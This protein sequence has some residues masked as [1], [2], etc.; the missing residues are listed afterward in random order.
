MIIKKNE[1]GCNMIAENNE[2]L[3]DCDRA[4]VRSCLLECGYILF[5]G[6]KPTQ[7]AFE[8]FTSSFGDCADTRHVH[9]PESGEGLGFHAEDAYNPYRPDTIWFFCYFQGTDGGVP[10]GVVDGV[11]IFKQLPKPWQSFCRSNQFIFSRQWSADIW[12]ALENKPSQSVI[13]ATLDAIPNI[14]FAFLPNGFI[15]IDTMVPIV[16]KTPRQ[17]ESFANTML[18]AISD[19]EY[20]GMMLANGETVPAELLS[21]IQTLCLENE[22]EVGWQTGDISV[23][24]N[25][26]MMHRRSFY[27]QVDRD[28]RVRHC[29]NFYGTVLPRSDSVFTQWIKQ[30]IQGDI[31][32]PTSIGSPLNRIPLT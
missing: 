18:Q 4:L 19:P 31:A 21:I 26:R 1:L 3:C 32:L 11:E 15:Q 28:L 10:T 7:Q 29:E 14:D 2:T 24:D 5:K 20:Y 27:K 8:D 30:L 25:F 6:F 13:E 16:I 12:E 22:K 17:Q 23:I 9:Y